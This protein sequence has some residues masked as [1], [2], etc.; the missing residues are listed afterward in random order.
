[1]K[2][3]P[4]LTSGFRKNPRGGHTWIWDGIRGY[5]NGSS[6][7]VDAIHCNWEW[8]NPSGSYPVV[9]LNGWYASY[10]QPDPNQ[11]S[12]LDDNV[13]LYITE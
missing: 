12:Y 5:V 11:E 9:N 10:E 13:Q 7:E 1:M 4:H 3:N 8:N 6:I 2:G